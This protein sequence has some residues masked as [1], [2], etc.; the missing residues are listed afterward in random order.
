MEQEVDEHL[1]KIKNQ[2]EKLHI[3]YKKLTWCERLVKDDPDKAAQYYLSEEE[4]RLRQNQ[5]VKH[6]QHQ[7]TV[8]K[9]HS[10]SDARDDLPVIS[11]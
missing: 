1:T 8:T 11:D 5:K 10:S 9:S 2:L 3:D 4:V 6:Q 7:D